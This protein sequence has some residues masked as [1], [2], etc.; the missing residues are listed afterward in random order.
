MWV[1]D[2]CGSDA[3]GSDAFGSD[4]FGSSMLP[5]WVSDACGSPLLLSNACYSMVQLLVLSLVLVLLM[6]VTS[7]MA[8]TG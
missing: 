2:A 7:S 3:F 8:R 5:M 4:A 6:P 1:S